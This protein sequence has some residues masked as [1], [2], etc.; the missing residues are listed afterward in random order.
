MDCKHDIICSL[1]Q[2]SSASC[3]R[4]VMGQPV[5][6]R[7]SMG[8]HTIEKEVVHSIDI[9]FGS[10]VVQSHPRSTYHTTEPMMQPMSP[11]TR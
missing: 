2:S 8:F 10:P 1:K 5:L 7:Q 9:E 4:E 6:A 3:S 11:K